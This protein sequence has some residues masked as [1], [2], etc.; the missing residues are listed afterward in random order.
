VHGAGGTQR[1]VSGGDEVAERAL[2]E[3]GEVE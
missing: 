3:A 1:Q 2:G